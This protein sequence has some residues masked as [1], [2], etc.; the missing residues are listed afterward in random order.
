MPIIMY[1]V[2]SLSKYCVKG[3]LYKVN[4]VLGGRGVCIMCLLLVLSNSW[5]VLWVI[6]LF[7]N[8][9]RGM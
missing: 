7:I 9:R 6:I 3:D 2:P 4:L 1:C 8:P 5:Q